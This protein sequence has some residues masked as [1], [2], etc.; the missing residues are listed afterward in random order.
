MGSKSST[1]VQKVY[2]K[3]TSKKIV[4]GV[5]PVNLWKRWENRGF[6]G[7]PPRTLRQAQ[8]GGGG[9]GKRGG[10]YP[11]SLR[12]R[13]QGD[14]GRGFRGW[15]P[16]RGGSGSRKETPACAGMTW[17]RRGDKA[18]G[19]RGR[20]PPLANFSTFSREKFYPRINS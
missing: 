2:R 15:P 6:R 4:T 3:L 10:P 17:V 18:A 5:T 8:C 7:W 20:P 19:A 1:F 12:S 11:L 13:V 16:R 9:S 14:I